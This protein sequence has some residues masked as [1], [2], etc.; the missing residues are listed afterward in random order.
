MK[1]ILNPSRSEWTKS[2]KRPVQKTKDIEK[3]VKPILR[4]VK[5]SGDKALKKFALEYD[6]VQIKNL[7]VTAEEVKKAKELVDPQ[8]KS[9]ILV[10]KENIEKFHAAQIS[11]ELKLEV[12]E[13]VTCMRRSVP[14]Q[15][16]GLYIPGGTAPLFSTVL[17]L[18]VPANLA[19]CEEIVL[20]TP[21]DA[22]GN[23]HPA[24]LYTADLIGIDKIVK[25]GGAQ[26]IAAMTFGTESV[27]RVDKIF[28]P[29]NQ[30]VTAA[31][32]LA[33]KKGVAIDMPA[34]PS[35][36]LVYADETAIPSFVAADLL[37]QAEHGV[38][39]QVVLVT[40][41][42]KFASKVQKE[43]ENQLE[44]LPRKDI[45]KRALD[46]SVAVVMAKQ[47]KAIELINDYAPEHLIICVENEEEVVDKIINAGSVFIGNF[48][49][50]SAGD[51]ASGTN[52]TLPTY[53]YARNYSGV[54]LD[55]FFKKITYQK[56]TEKGIQKLGPT[57]E[58]MAANELLDAHK[59]AVS[60]RLNYLKDKK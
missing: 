59:N 15:K 45:A 20:C 46:N 40:T 21:P 10:A 60:I 52:H 31:K 23:I 29:G 5:R 51:Y 39:S 2:L 42:E 8:L 27:P 12:M 7:C 19:G 48:T 41:T 55:S 37:S 47:E 24:I 35:E 9:A 38:D 53:G 25:A 16:V 18:G 22:E 44:K 26:A 56:I 43:I 58:I 30:Y 50:E 4:K 6:H 49:P 17:M 3:I 54:S 33:V 57:I 36:V 13:G 32:Q 14:I 28:G 11:P 34:G 1:T